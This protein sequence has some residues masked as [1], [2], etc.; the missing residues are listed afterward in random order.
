MSLTRFVL[1]TKKSEKLAEHVAGF[2]LSFDGEKMLLQ[3]GH[4]ESDGGAANSPA[5][6]F[7]IVPAD[8]PVK[9]GEGKLDLSKMQVRI[10]PHA[11][12][13]Q[14]FHEVWQIERSF[15]YDPHYHLSLIH[16]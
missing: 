4:G 10:D 16:I 11:E 15:F 12:W 6:T 3:M 5:P 13:R 2:D 14:M 9:P 8:A 1:K 7:V